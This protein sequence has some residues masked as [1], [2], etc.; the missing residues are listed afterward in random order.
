MSWDPHPT[1]WGHAYVTVKGK[2]PVTK[3]YQDS[4]GDWWQIWGKQALCYH[5]AAIG[6][7]IRWASIAGLDLPRNPLYVC[8][9]VPESLIV[10][11]CLTQFMMDLLSPIDQSIPNNCATQQI[12]PLGFLSWYGLGDPMRYPLFIL[13]LFFILL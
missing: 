11:H 6:T 5:M 2:L 10:S 7:V 1:C 13:T 9:L 4:K 8:S 12:Q 3:M